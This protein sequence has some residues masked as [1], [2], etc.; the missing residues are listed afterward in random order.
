M[1]HLENTFNTI[2]N[3]IK[4]DKYSSRN[5]LLRDFSYIL[6]LLVI[7]NLTWKTVVIDKKMFSHYWKYLKMFS[8]H[9]TLYPFFLK[10]CK[11]IG[12]Y[13]YSRKV[14]P[15]VHATNFISKDLHNALTL[16]Y[17]MWQLYREY[18]KNLSI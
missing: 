15:K 4:T 6:N 13:E 1:L 9:K 16:L 7:R 3:I 12:V 14:Y 17:I 10:S 18:F 2:S 8:A 11:Y 5:I